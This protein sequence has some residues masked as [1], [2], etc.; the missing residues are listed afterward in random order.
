MS[1][2]PCK[3]QLRIC[4]DLRTWIANEIQ[5]E[6]T[7]MKERRKVREGRLSANPRKAAKSGGH[8]VGEG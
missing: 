5:K 8:G 6:S 2:C 3:S 1:G 4:P 7:V